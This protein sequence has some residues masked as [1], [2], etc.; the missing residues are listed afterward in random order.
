MMINKAEVR[1]FAL[2]TAANSKFRIVAGAKA[3]RF[4]RMSDSF[5]EHINAMTMRAITERI[6]QHGNSGQTLT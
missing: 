3:P 4:T 5:F 1:R 6:G 2:E